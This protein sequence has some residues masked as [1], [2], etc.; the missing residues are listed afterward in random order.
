MA[1]NDKKLIIITGA[2]GTGKTTVSHY[3]HDQ[4]HATR[5]LTHT[6][7]A[8]RPGEVDGQDYYFETPES[9][10]NNHFVEYVNYAGNL[11]GSSVEGMQRA[12]AKNDLACMVLDTKGAET[13]LRRFPDLVCVIYLTVKDPN[14][15]RERMRQRGDSRVALQQRLN[16]EEYMRDLHLPKSLQNHVAIIMNEDW[17]ETKAKLDQV[18]ANATVEQQ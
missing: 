10:F 18:M 3:L 13:Y 1:I 17:N 6:T 16:S 15:L 4:Y 7:R 5:V 8:P 14:Q 2:A 12:L 9:F 11:Y